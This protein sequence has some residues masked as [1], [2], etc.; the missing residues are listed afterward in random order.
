MKTTMEFMLAVQKKEQLPTPYAVA[1]FLGVSPTSLYRYMDGSQTMDD[2]TALK[3]AKALGLDPMGVIAAANAERAKTEKERNDWAAIIKKV[4]GRAAGF[5]LILSIA[6]LSQ[7]ID[8]KDS[9]ANSIAVDV[10]HYAHYRM[11]PPRPDTSEFPTGRRMN[12]QSRRT[13]MAPNNRY[14]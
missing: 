7:V 11:D 5:M 1:K 6:L 8:I 13:K 12:I 3:V 9:Y 2:Y 4:G 14:D 10:K